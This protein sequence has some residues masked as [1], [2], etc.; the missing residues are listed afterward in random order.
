V[1][2]IVIVGFMGSGKTTVAGE[3]ALRLACH[4]IDLDS[5]ITDRSGRG[6]AEIIREDGEDFFREVE[7]R[8]LR[9]VLENVEA[10]VVALGGGT[11][12]M[13]ANRDL[14]AK[15]EG[16]TVWLD[17]P[18]DLCW[19]RIAAN[20]GGTRP[21]APDPTTARELYERRRASYGLAD[22]RIEVTGEADVDR[23]VGQI[24]TQ[25]AGHD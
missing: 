3:L 10:E 14:I 23:V 5:F 17:T 19:Q 4:M 24:I 13:A 20:D 12:T 9:Y 1:R 22:L 7:T 16:L 6:P 21:L 25:V 15:H 18:F 8:T 11:W 2:R